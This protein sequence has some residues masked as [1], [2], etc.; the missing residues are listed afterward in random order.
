MELVTQIDDKEVWL[1]IF[2]RPYTLEIPFGGEDF[3]CVLFANDPSVTPEEQ[4][5][6]SRELVAAGCKFALCAGINASSWH[7]AIDDAYLATDENYSPPDE[8]MIMTTWHENESLAE[9]MW[10]ALHCTDF[11]D[12]HFRKLLVLL[13]GPDSKVEQEV[14]SYLSKPE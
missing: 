4:Y 5:S 9:V 12:H 13:V 11:D 6:Q 3:V 10:V 8:T 2:S 7:D 14:R 1:E